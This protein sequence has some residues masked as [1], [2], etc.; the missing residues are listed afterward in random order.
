MT[1]MIPL[2]EFTLD[3]LEMLEQLSGMTFTE[4]AENS[5]RPK[6]IKALLWISAKRLDPNAKMEDIGKLSLA[7]ASEIMTGADDPK[8]T[9]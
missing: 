2:D 1:K 8:A 3:E 6:I 7:E 4:I 9:E 5:S